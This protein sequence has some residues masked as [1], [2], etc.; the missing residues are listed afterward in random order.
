MSTPVLATK[1]FVPSLRPGLVLR[2]RLIDHLNAASQRRLT[3]VSAP[4]GYGKTTLINSWLHE[5]RIP[6]AWFSLEEEDNDPSRFLGYFTLALQRLAP[7]IGSDLLGMFQ[8]APSAPYETLVTLLINQIAELETPFILVLDD[9]HVIHAQ[10]ILEVFAFLLERMPPQ[11]HLVLLSRTDPSLPLA[12]LR[13][14]DQILDI[15]ADQLRFTLDETAIFLNEVMGLKIS[16]LQTA[17][18]RSTARRSME[19]TIPEK[20]RKAASMI[21]RT[22]LLPEVS[23]LIWCLLCMDSPPTG[24]NSGFKRYSD[25]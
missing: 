25:D 17:S 2:C 12:R 13:A 7:A 8:G 10:A 15:R 5:T 18:E 1:F 20:K 16:A 22:R 14:R 9:F 11:M 24:A 6:S 3:L 4:A 21:G 23:S 19:R